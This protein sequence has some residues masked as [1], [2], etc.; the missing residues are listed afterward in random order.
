MAKYLKGY[1]L[2]EEWETLKK[3]DVS[4][5]LPLINAVEE[6]STNPSERNIQIVKQ[7]E[8]S[9]KE[10]VMNL[11]KEDR[12]VLEAMLV[13][14]LY[15]AGNVV[16]NGLKRW[17]FTMLRAKDK[18]LEEEFFRLNDAIMK[19]E[20][21]AESY[22]S[23]GSSNKAYINQQQEF[24]ELVDNA[25]ADANSH[26]EKNNYISKYYNTF[27]EKQVDRKRKVI[28]RQIKHFDDNTFGEWIHNLRNSKG[29]SLAVAGEETG[30]SPSYI[31]RIEKGVRNVPSVTKLE[32]LAKGFGVPSG[33]MISMASGGIQ[34][35]SAYI[36]QGAYTIDNK[37]ATTE[38]KE[39]ISELIQLI[40]EKD[41]NG[42]VEQLDNLLR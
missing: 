21:L 15:Q 7:L 9:L 2:T 37:L 33:E 30:V 29:W 23:S 19:S 4:D 17:D 5:V 1:T 14:I 11:E 22:Q 38:Q 35:I 24:L 20:E 32:Q 6:L 10:E 41:K 27:F 40:L 31:H 26:I 42:A 12:D 28:K 39:N 3:K 13:R 16:N 34:P 36:E 25:W 8:D 18:G